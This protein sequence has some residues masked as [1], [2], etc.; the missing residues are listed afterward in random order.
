MEQQNANNRPSENQGSV[1]GTRLVLFERS[2]FTGMG[3]KEHDLRSEASRSHPKVRTCFPNEM[4]SSTEPSPGP[5]SEKS[6]SSTFLR[7]KGE[8]RRKSREKKQMGKRGKRKEQTSVSTS[9]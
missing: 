4:V 6:L 7:E 9:F 3:Q 5:G 1:T 8:R 2:S